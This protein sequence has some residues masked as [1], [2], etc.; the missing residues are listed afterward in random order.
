MVSVLRR[1]AMG[2]VGLPDHALKV[3][4]SKASALKVDGRTMVR[5]L[6]LA[7]LVMVGAMTSVRE[8]A[9]IVRLDG[10]MIRSGKKADAWCICLF[11]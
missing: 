1:V 3:N 9:G 4:V 8:M 11:C 7:D 2:I 6:G 10:L 5:V